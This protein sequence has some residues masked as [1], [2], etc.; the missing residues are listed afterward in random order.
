MA[1]GVPAGVSHEGDGN[2]DQVECGGGEGDAFPGPVAVTHERGVEDY[3][4]D[5]DCDPGRDAEETEAGAD[6]DELGDQSEEV[7]DAE[8]DHGEPSPE[9]TEA[10]ED[11]FGV[12]AMGGGA[13]ADGHFLDDDGHAEGEDDEGK[14]ESDAEFG[15][16]G[17][18]GEH[19]GAVVFAQHDEDAGT[20]EQPQQARFRGKAA[21]GAGGGDADAI[22]GAVD[23]FVGDD[24]F[25]FG[26]G[27]DR[28]HRLELVCG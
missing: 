1:D 10:V 7:A 24:Y 14:E 2:E 13:E 20:D 28:L 27:E 6:G 3:Q 23:V 4:R 19:A 12:S 9:G 8:V 15:A 16:G 5:E 11:E 18:V 25:L 21:L 17:G 26:L 22:V